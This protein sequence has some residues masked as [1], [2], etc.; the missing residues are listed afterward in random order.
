MKPFIDDGFVHKDRRRSKYNPD[1]GVEKKIDPALEQRIWEYKERI[2]E[3]ITE[4]SI[5]ELQKIVNEVSYELDN[6]PHIE[7]I[8]DSLRL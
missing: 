2:L 8:Q 4:K 1:D 3:H 6:D 5:F 7:Y